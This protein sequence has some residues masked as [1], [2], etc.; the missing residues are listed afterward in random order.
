M[1]I[2]THTDTHT[3]C[4]VWFLA[5]ADSKA[6]FPSEDDG[7]RGGAV[8]GGGGGGGRRGGNGG[9]LRNRPK[10]TV[11][12]VHSWHYFLRSIFLLDWV[13]FAPRLGLFWKNS[14]LR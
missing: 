8:G 12:L 11:T 6:L 3:Q 13:Y 2:Y 5:A 4:Q 7:E 10:T 9:A 1:H 14:R